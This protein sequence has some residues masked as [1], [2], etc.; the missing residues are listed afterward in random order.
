[1]DHNPSWLYN[2]RIPG[3]QFLAPTQATAFASSS[4]ASAS[5]GAVAF[6]GGSQEFKIDHATMG[7]RHKNNVLIVD[8]DK[9]PLGLINAAQRSQVHFTPKDPRALTVPYVY[10]ENRSNLLKHY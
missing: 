8:E 9:S 3:N 2:E 5:M 6:D 1:M 4:L 10:V 7:N